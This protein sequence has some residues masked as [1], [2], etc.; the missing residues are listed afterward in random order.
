MILT[1]LLRRTIPVFIVVW[2]RFR[3]LPFTS[4][5]IP[6]AAVAASNWLVNT[7]KTAVG[8]SATAGPAPPEP[9]ERARIQADELPRLRARMA[10]LAS[11]MN[12]WGLALPSPAGGGGALAIRYLAPRYERSRYLR[13]ARS[14]PTA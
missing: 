5:A 1:S 10:R 8:P 3:R 13:E 12:F 11:R 6:T 4:G 7:S 9:L 14:G 2:T